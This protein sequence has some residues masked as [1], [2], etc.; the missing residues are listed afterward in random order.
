LLFTRKQ[1]YFRIDSIYGRNSGVLRDNMEE[2]DSLFGLVVNTKNF[3]R[4]S[5]KVYGTRYYTRVYQV[6]G[7]MLISFQRMEFK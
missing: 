1:R 4:S 7:V 6:V 5:S 3:S 2:F